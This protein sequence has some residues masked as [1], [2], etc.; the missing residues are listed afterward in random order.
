MEY[1]KN[2]S[3]SIGESSNALGCCY[4]RSEVELDGFTSSW[5]NYRRVEKRKIKH[6]FRNLSKCDKNIVELVR[7][8]TKLTS[9]CEIFFFAETPGT[10][11]I[12]LILHEIFP[13]CVRIRRNVS[14]RDRSNPSRRGAISCSSRHRTLR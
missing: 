6:C 9:S 14:R 8:L 10:E 3:H 2:C 7:I 13:K 11:V 4:T 1:L 12:A 5:T